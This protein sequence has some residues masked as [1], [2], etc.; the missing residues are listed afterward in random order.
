MAFVL[1][2]E[3]GRWVFTKAAIMLRAVTTWSCPFLCQLQLFLQAFPS[4][5]EHPFLS[6]EGLSDRP[7]LLPE[8]W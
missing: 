8:L 7:S 4:R 3:L 1:S 5:L 6:A 2:K